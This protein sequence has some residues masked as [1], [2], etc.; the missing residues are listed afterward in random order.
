VAKGAVE[1]VLPDARDKQISIE[2]QTAVPVRMVADRG[3][4]DIVL[5]NLLSNAVKYNREGGRVTVILG[6]H[7]DQVHIAVSDTGIGM[8]SQEARQ[9]FQ[10]FFR[11]KNP[12]TRNISGS[13]LGL[14]IVK[15]IA[16]LYGGDVSV[17]SEDGVG[18]TF[19]VLLKQTGA[20]DANAFPVVLESE[21]P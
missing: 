19:T 15:K 3:E 12:H 8:T 10:E 7:H 2:L 13:G 1:T 9:L 14:S 5:N 17:Q 4:M 20:R 6:V 18:S 11:V 21:K 16:T